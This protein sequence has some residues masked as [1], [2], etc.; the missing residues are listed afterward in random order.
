MFITV[1]F[2]KQRENAFST[3]ESLHAHR[4]KAEMPLISPPDR[5]GRYGGSQ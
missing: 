3:F 5:C 1:R 4:R 2:I